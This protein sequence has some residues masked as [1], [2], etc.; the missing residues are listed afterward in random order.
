M[1]VSL[2]TAASRKKTNR[3]DVKNN[4]EEIILRMSTSGPV[5][6]Y[7]LIKHI[8]K[9]FGVSLC[10]SQV[11]PCLWDLNEKGYL[12]SDVEQHDGKERK[13]YHAVSTRTVE[14][15]KEIRD[16]KNQNRRKINDLSS[17]IFNV[18]FS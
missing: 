15:L 13:V 2:T 14:R 5:Y 10:Q 3:R 18:Q 4:L 8:K 11:Y 17:D 9:T 6:G 7:N 16:V 12:S 1:E